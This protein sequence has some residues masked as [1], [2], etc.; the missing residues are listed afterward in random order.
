MA[1]VFVTRDSI[2][3]IDIGSVSFSAVQLDPEGNILRRFYQFHKGNIPESF[4]E[5]SKIFDPADIKAIACTSSSI[6]LNKKYVLN[7][8]SQVAIIAAV[9]Q[10]CRDAAS[11]LHIGAEKFMLIKFDAGGNYQSTK[12]NTSCAAGTGSFLDQQVDRLN[13]TGIEELCERAL[14]NTEEIPVIASRCA[15]FSNTDII[16]AQQRGYSVSAIC[17]SLCK[18]LAENIN[19]TVF[20]IE[21]PVLPIL[22]TGGVSKNLVVS[23]L[24][25]ENPEDNLLVE[26]G[27]PSLW[28]YRCR[29]DASERK[30]HPYTAGYSLIR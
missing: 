28:S 5:A 27:F 15:V 7:Y 12:I 4:K 17:T 26:C 25:G 29:P 8:N 13:L 1:K 11:V 9:R 3:G 23:R 19:N 16:H 20:N 30:K 24:S 18:G 10:L 21:P 6:C 22:I 14:K 2:L